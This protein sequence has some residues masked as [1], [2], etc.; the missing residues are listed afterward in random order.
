MRYSRG[1]DAMIVFAEEA[2]SMMCCFVCVF[3]RIRMTE[4]LFLC[5]FVRKKGKGV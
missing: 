1:R 5:V 4:K 3:L 2:Y